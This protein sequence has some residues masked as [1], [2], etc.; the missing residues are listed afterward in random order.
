MSNASPRFVKAALELPSQA[1]IAAQSGL[2]FLQAILEGRLPAPPISEVLNYRLDSVEAGRVVFRGK[3]M[4]AAMN[5][6]GSI[7]GGWFGTLLDSSMSCAVQSCLPKGSGYT[8]L[9][10]KVN[11][12]RPLVADGPEVLAIGT[13]IHVG[14][15][16]GAAEGRVVGAENG[17][18]YAT[19]TA[20]CL[21]INL[22]G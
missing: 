19:G 9:E 16:T 11:M 22:D 3:P 18:V 10:Y 8:T 20:T 21:V 17:K 7:H 12:L 5:P 15:R 14:R 4:L 13:A 1:D 6:I 2:A